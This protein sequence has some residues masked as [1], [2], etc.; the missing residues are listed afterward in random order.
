MHL[1]VCV[2][3]DAA[4]AVHKLHFNASAHPSYAQPS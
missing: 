4:A 1:L 3:V 2:V